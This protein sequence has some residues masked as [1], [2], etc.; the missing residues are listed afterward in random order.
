MYVDGF[1]IPDFSELIS[2]CRCHPQF[3]AILGIGRVA[4]PTK[5]QVSGYKEGTSQDYLELYFES[6]KRS[7]GCEDVTVYVD[8]VENYATIS[9]PDTEGEI[10]FNL[11]LAGISTS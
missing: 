2:Y 10:V 7:G 1:V 5:L 4:V 6:A 3:G 11:S 9:F 8:E